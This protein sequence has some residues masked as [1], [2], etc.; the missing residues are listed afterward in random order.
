MSRDL[1]ARVEELAGNW[2]VTEQSW[3]RVVHYLE[4]RCQELAAS[5]L[6]LSASDADRRAAAE[7]H[8]ELQR[9][10]NAPQDRRQRA[11]ALERGFAEQRLGGTY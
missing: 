7:R 3:V 11:E 10:M 5:A 6:S 8:D 9:L 2:P 4:A 1:R